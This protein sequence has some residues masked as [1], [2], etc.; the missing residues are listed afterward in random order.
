MGV[1]VKSGAEF[2]F[3]KMTKFWRG[4]V[5]M[6]VRSLPRSLHLKAVKMASTM[7]LLSQLRA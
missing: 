2:Q 7:Y 5:L 4:I 1:S 6:V 3:R